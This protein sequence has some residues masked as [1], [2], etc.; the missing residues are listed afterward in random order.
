[1]L[2]LPDMSTPAV[3]ALIVAGIALA[4]TLHTFRGTFQPIVRPVVPQD[5][6][7]IILKNVGRGPA[8][9][10][11]IAVR[12]AANE[13]DYVTNADIIEPLGAPLGPKFD[14]SSRIGRVWRRLRGQPSLIVGKEY[15]IFYQGL[16]GA[17]HRTDFVVLLEGPGEVRFETKF[18]GRCSGWWNLRVV[19]AWVQQRGQVVL[20][21]DDDNP[22]MAAKHHD[23]EGRTL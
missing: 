9:A 20:A 4:S 21:A 15:Y 8:I 22:P 17:W 11:V 16:A 12:P 23:D 3:A 18:R 5:P 7:G 6:S 2:F 19:P 14:E 1:M 13:A 10:V